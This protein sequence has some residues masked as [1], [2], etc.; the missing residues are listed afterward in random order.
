MTARAALLILSYLYPLWGMI[1]LGRAIGQ[2]F[3]MLQKPGQGPVYPT[4]RDA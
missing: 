3:G 1:F 2:I 4:V